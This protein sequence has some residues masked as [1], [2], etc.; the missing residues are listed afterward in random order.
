ML[1][2][3]PRLFEATILQSTFW[4]TSRLRFFRKHLLMLLMAFGW[5]FVNSQVAVASHDCP[6][7]ISLQSLSIQHSD[8]ML[9]N[10]TRDLAKT[11]GMLCEKHCIPDVMQKDN[12]HTSLAALPTANTLA[13]VVP[14]CNETVSSVALISPPATGPPA[15]I[16]FCRFRE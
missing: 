14:E 3:A 11:K 9:M 10:S 4:S 13:L 8:H 12:G 15:T 6:V 5:L 2:L 1:I 16:R 7:N